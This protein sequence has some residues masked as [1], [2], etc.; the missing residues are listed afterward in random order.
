MRP[1]WSQ[2]RPEWDQDT[3]RVGPG[4]WDP[5]SGSRTVVQW[6]LGTRTHTTV[7]YQYTHHCPTHHYP[8]YHYTG[9]PTRT[10]HE[11]Y[12]TQSHAPRAVHQA[13]F[14]YSQYLN[15]ATPADTTLFQY[16]D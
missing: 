15:Y 7:G 11:V 6:G 2:M 16:P 3:A 9:A 4:Q 13:P 1:G 8:G 10:R 14:T 12:R 5:D